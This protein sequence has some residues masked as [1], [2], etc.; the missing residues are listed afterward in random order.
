MA[1]VTVFVDDAV[2]GRLPMVCV[3]TGEPADGLHRV[4]RGIGG[5]SGWAFLLIFL[6]PVGWIVLVALSVSSR[7]RDLLVRLPYTQ[8]ALDAERRA[9]QAAMVAFATAVLAGMGT[10]WLGASRAESQVRSVLFVALAVVAVIAVAAT[11]A[12]A[13]GYTAGRP[14]IELDASGRWVTLYR[15]HPAF[16]DALRERDTQAPATPRPT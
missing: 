16:A 15:V 4:H 11:L 13:I 7:S 6:G 12:V 8:S 9:F 5:L 10:A 3:R 2:L 14:A 1:Q